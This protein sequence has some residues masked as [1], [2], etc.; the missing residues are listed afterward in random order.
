MIQPTMPMAARGPTLAAIARL[1]PA[2][3]FLAST[4]PLDAGAPTPSHK[5]VLQSPSGITEVGLLDGAAYR[6]DVPAHWNHALVV[7]Y[8]GYALQPVTFHIA[9]RLESRQMPF[10]DRHY[11]VIQ[12]AYS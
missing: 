6:I 7:F 12:S 9:A 10:F 1:L 5:Q 8:H 4:L 2:V 3:L 11:A